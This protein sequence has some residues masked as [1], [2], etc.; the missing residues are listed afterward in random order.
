M[1]FIN[2]N[3]NKNVTNEEQKSRLI[4]GKE[5]KLSTIQ[6]FAEKK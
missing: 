3:K 2:E 1:A 6:S 5:I 4:K